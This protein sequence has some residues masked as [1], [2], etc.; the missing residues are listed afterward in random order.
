M[1]L[2]LRGRVCRDRPHR[3]QHAVDVLSRASVVDDARAQRELSP[4]FGARKKRLTAKLE[5]FEHRAI[6][7]GDRLFIAKVSTEQPEADNAQ[8]GRSRQ[9]EVRRATDTV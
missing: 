7:G 6:E 2:P 3:L 9:P 5:A 8:A 4:Q 1:G